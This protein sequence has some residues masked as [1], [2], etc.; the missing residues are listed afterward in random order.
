[1]SQKEEQLKLEAECAK[2]QRTLQILERKLKAHEDDVQAMSGD[3]AE[4]AEELQVTRFAHL[5]VLVYLVHVLEALQPQFFRLIP[6]LRC[7]VELAARKLNHRE[8]LPSNS[9]V[10]ECHQTSHLTTGICGQSHR[11]LPRAAA[12]DP[13]HQEHRHRNH[14]DEEDNRGARGKPRRAGAGAEVRNHGALKKKN[15]GVTSKRF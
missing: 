12:G 15:S 9:E 3:L 7:T 13:Q 10:S 14:S 8:E 6:V 11:D 4:R 1:L 5:A 2:H